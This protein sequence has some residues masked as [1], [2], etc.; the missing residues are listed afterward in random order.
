MAGRPRKSLLTRCDERSFRARDHHRL[1]G[2]EPDLPCPQLAE[3][4]Q[5]Y[6][7][8]TELSE[9]RWLAVEFQ[10]RLHG[11]HASAPAVRSEPLPP[12]AELV[13][14]L[15]VEEPERIS[16]FFARFLRHS[17]GPLA[18]QPF[19][20]APFQQQFVAEFYRR[21]EHNR[22]LYQLGLLGLPRG[23][24]KTSLAAGLALYELCART[25][26]P[27]I[28]FAGTSKSQA[29][30]AAELARALSET[31]ELARWLRYRKGLISCP[32]THGVA[33]TLGGDGRLHHGHNPTA[34]IVDELW[35]FQRRQELES[36]AALATSIPKRAG[37]S[38]LL[39]TTTAG[40]QRKGKLWTIHQHALTHPNCEQ[41]TPSLTTLRD[42]ESGFLFH[43]YAAPDNADP[44]DDHTLR[45][46]NPA[47]WLPLDQLR[48]LNHRDDL[49][50]NDYRRLILNQWPPD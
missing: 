38:Y 11:K 35:A 29:A 12:L 23:N 31:G 34:V 5:R 20:L 2:S 42:R 44:D 26:A 28:L 50:A 1:L 46:C 45:G 41:P 10:R 13:R 48:R 33:L 9:Q 32:A 43:W 21:D 39:A 36:Y 8:A 22:R 15:A 30:I 37:H 14:G 24:G 4:Q 25:D 27:Q 19:L 7:Q 40:P 17:R 18:G 16:A 49:T 3:L 47:P 6:R